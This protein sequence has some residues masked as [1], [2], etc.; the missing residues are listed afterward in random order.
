ML[1]AKRTVKAHIPPS[2]AHGSDMKYSATMAPMSKKAA[3]I[4]LMAETAHSTWRSRN[5]IVPSD[6]RPDALNGSQ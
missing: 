5:T 1:S 6:E 4:V 2:R 3:I